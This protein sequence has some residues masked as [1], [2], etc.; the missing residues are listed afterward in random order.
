MFTC[1]T[2]SHRYL[3]YIKVVDLY[4]GQSWYFPY[5]RYMHS[6][7]KHGQLAKALLKPAPDSVEG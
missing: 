2:L 6:D 3:K 4:T 1:F 7:Y 5:H